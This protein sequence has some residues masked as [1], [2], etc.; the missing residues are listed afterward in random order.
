MTIGLQD[1][2]ERFAGDPSPEHFHRLREQMVAEPTYNPAADDME[3]AGRL[4][5]DGEAERAREALVPVMTNYLLS[6]RA[7]LLL[8]VAC[9]R[10]GETEAALRRRAL[11]EACLRALLASGDGSA[12]RPYLVTRVSDEHDVLGH[13]GARWARQSLRRRDGRAF[14]VFDLEG[15]GEVWFDITEAL[16]RMGD[17]FRA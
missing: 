9:E 11:A 7:H 6:P 12:T 10:L 2:F 5:A 8:A 13:V 1:L 17:R 14:D 15:G 4:L 16:S 3:V